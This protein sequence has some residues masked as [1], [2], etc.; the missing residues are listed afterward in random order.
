MKQTLCFGGKALERMAQ[1]LLS[2]RKICYNEIIFFGGR[3]RRQFTSSVLSRQ[4]GPSFLRFGSVFL[5]IIVEN[6]KGQVETLQEHQT[7]ASFNT[8]LPI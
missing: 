5:I 3:E 1:P 2:R 7:D 6:E 4:H 8:A